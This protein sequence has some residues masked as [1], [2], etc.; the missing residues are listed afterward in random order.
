[1]TS[2][3]RL[4]YASQAVSNYVGDSSAF[5]DNIVNGPGL[6]EGSHLEDYIE[7][8]GVGDLVATDD[9]MIISG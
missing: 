3:E 4:V 5:E 8:M 9:D 7:P 2:T 1:V 6:F